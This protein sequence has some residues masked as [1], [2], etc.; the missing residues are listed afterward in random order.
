MEPGSY[1][2]LTAWFLSRLVVAWRK[3]LGLKVGRIAKARI[4]PVYGSWTTTV[5]FEAWVR[6]SAESSARSAMNWMFSS[7]VRTR[8]SPG[9]G[10]RSWLSSTWRRASSAVSMRPGTPCR[11]LVVFA[12]HA[13]EAIVIGAHVS[14]DL[15]GKL[16][17]GIE[18]LE[19]L[20]EIHAFEIQR[21]HPR[22]LRGVKFA[23]DPG[24]VS[25][26]VQPGR[27][28]MRGSEAVGGVGV[29]DFGQG[30][31]NSLPLGSAGSPSAFL[32]DGVDRIGQRGH[33]QL[34]QIAI[35]EDS[36]ARRD[37]EGAL[38]LPGGTVHEVLVMDDLQPDQAAADQ[39]DPGDKEERNMSKPRRRWTVPA[40]TGRS[41]RSH[42]PVGR[43]LRARCGWREKRSCF[44]CTCHAE[45]SHPR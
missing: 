2:S 19:F 14:Q 22:D 27:N 45:D 9:S 38:L 32:K 40:Y 39:D 7:M 8:F 37:L 33:G 34:M 13:S 16:A 1:T 3:S 11:S 43:R 4:W 36:A 29:H 24:E 25:R 6:S 18:A 42:P 35:V 44:N 21:F 31:G 12:L 20:L 41:R 5:P 15:R 30:S 10:S 26:G 28:L 17:V 23:R